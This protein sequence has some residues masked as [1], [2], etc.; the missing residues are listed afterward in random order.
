MKE[1][2]KSLD[3]AV[4]HFYTKLSDDCIF[5]GSTAGHLLNIPEWNE[6]HISMAESLVMLAHEDGMDED[7]EDLMITKR[8]M[9]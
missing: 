9:E 4:A 6:H 5:W 1:L 3:L 8:K 7:G 2:R